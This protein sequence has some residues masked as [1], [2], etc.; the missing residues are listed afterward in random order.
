MQTFAMLTRLD[1]SGP[2]RP[3]D[4]LETEVV[5]RV[6]EECPK[7]KWLGSFAVLGPHDY[8][9]LFSASDCEEAMKVASIVRSFGHAETETWPVVEWKRFKKVAAKMHA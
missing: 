9:D 2:Q 5:E 6:G 4:E 7:V 8:L 3:V 1:R